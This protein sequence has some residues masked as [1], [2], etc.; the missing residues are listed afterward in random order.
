MDKWRK[1]NGE[2]PPAYTDLAPPAFVL[3][4]DQPP[5]PYYSV[6]ESPQPS[7]SSETVQFLPSAGQRWPAA[8]PDTVYFIPPPLPWQQSQRHQLQQQQQQQQQ[9]LKSAITHHS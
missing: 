4:S 7:P 1:T 5:P 3:Y 9:V 6:S 8:G 2:S